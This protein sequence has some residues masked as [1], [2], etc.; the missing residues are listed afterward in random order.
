MIFKCTT[1]VTCLQQL[2][3]SR[4]RSVDAVCLMTVMVVCGGGS[5]HTQPV[6][7][8]DEDGGVACNVAPLGR[9]Y[10]R[11]LLQS[12]TRSISWIT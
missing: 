9:Q 10:H 3:D 1:T 11:L 12:I 2:G 5:D 4:F 8:V 7:V 6:S